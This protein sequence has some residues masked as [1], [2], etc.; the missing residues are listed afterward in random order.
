M[1]KNQRRIVLLVLIIVAAVILIFAIFFNVINNKYLKF[2]MPELYSPSTP[3][4]LSSKDKFDYKNGKFAV[5]QPSYTALSTLLVFEN[6]TRKTIAKGLVNNCQLI[7]SGIY[8]VSNK[9]L[10]FYDFENGKRKEILDG[11]ESFLLLSGYLVTEEN[12]DLLIREIEAP[13]DIVR[14]IDSIYSYCV[15]GDLICAYGYNGDVVSIFVVEDKITEKKIGTTKVTSFPT[16]ISCSE[17]RVAVCNFHGITVFDLSG[18]DSDAKNLEGDYHGEISAVCAGNKL[19]FSFY[20]VA[21]NGS[22][23]SFV[24]SEYNGIWEIDLNTLETHLISKVPLRSLFITG[25]T[26][27]VFETKTNKCVSLKLKNEYP[28]ND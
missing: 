28:D 18:N 12:N 6:G 20:A 10:I 3:V 23:A 24:N 21:E 1:V 26:L 19:Y 2:N 5:I 14:K 7:E 4:F 13:Y 25:N 22:F 15:C 27:L 11:V 16:V 8:Y 9:K 17:T